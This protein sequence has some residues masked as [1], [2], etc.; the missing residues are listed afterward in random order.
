MIKNVKAGA[1]K[2]LNII[3]SLLTHNGRIDQK[4]LL[5]IQKMVILS[6]IRYDEEAYGSASHTTLKAL[7]P[8]PYIISFS[9]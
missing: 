8:I 9:R 5:K 3:K 7:N 6:T 2:K 4:T 1:E